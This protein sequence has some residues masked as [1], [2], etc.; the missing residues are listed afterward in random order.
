MEEMAVLQQSG[1]ATCVTRQRFTA[2]NE[3][4]CSGTDSGSSTGGTGGD[5]TNGDGADG[6]DGDGTDLDNSTAGGLTDN[7]DDPGMIIA[8]GTHCAGNSRRN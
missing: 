6:V 4:P 5:G 2:C 7:H 1:E 8:T 3:Q